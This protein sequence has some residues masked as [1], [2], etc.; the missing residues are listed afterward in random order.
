ML[1]LLGWRFSKKPENRLPFSRSFD[2]LGVAVDFSASDSGKVVIRNKLDRVDGIAAQVDEI[3]PE[4]ACKLSIAASLR[5]R[6]R[7]AEGRLYG[8]AVA[9]RTP[10][11]RN[12]APGDD[13]VSQLREQ[14]KAK[15][16]LGRG[17]LAIG[18]AAHA[19]G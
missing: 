2:V 4:G 10:S 16:L 8:R 6:F 7:F 9:V 13:N 1:E 19:F 14:T 11:F 18:C 5:G 15:T 12:R 17:I 3:V